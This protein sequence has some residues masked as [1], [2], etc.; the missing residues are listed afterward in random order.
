MPAEF[1]IYWYACTETFWKYYSCGKHYDEHHSN[2]KAV[3]RGMKIENMDD[4]IRKMDFIA[5]EI[6][7]M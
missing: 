5:E 4:L 1:Y 6:Y 2:D 3:T 7:D